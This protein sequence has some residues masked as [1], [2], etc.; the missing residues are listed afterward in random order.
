[1]AIY[2]IKRFLLKITKNNQKKVNDFI[3]LND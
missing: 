3:D 1:M 2:L